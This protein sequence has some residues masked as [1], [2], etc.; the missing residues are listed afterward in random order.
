MNHSGDYIVVGAGSAGCVLANRLSANPANTVILLE[1]GGKDTNPWI[2][3]PVGYFKTIHNPKT[4]WCYETEPDPGLNGRAI[5]WPR[6]RVLGGSSSINGLLYVRGQRE[7]YD[8]W[9]QLGNSGWSFEDVLPYFRKSED[10]QNGEDEYHGTGGPLKVSDMSFKRPIC[11]DFI[12]AVQELDV[13]LSQDINGEVQEGVGYFQLT[14]HKGRRCSTAVGFLKPVINRPNLTVITHAQAE[15]LI[16]ENGRATGIT[17]RRNGTTC[18]A[19]ANREVILSS[20]AVNSP[21]LLQLSGIGPGELLQD[22]GIAVVKD[23]PD[24]GGNLQ[25]HLQIRTVYKTT[26]A[27]TLN[28]ELSNPLQKGRA[29]LEYLLTRSGPLS[30]AASQVVAFC[31]TRLSNDRPDIQYHFQPLSADSPGEGLHP[32]SAITASVCQLRPTSRGHIQIKSTD[33]LAAPRITP[34]YLSTDLDCQTAV[35]SIKFTRNIMQS[36]AMKPHIKSEYLPDSNAT[37]DDE[38][39]EQARNISNTIY[40]PT[41]TCRMGTDSNAVVD[42]RLRVNGVDG[43]RV[44]DASIMPE[45]VSGNTNAPTIMIAEKAADMI[46]EDQRAI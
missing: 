31:K 33:P 30:M 17:Y 11:D 5:K 36:N 28:D 44:V 34:N 7:D 24:V 45:I 18:T 10:Q 14:A 16:I 22:L 20:G 4:D 25:D 39:L 2:H 21:Q 46:L 26:S 41:S 35:E 42:P 13:P 27:V 32:F 37:T 9:A 40:H 6:G 12:Q 3:I 19:T 23:A 8:H 43:L 29:A 15:K 1:A 38:L